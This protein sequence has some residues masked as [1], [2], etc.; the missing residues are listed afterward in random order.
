MRP[1]NHISKAAIAIVLLINVASAQNPNPRYGKWKLKSNAPAPMSNIMTYEP[2]GGHGMKI[3][4]DAV[5][6][7]GVKSQWFYTTN[8]DGKDEPI[9]G[10]PGADTGSV[11]VINSAI[12][13]IVYKKDGKI[14]QVLTN[15]LSPDRDTIGIIYMRM[16][17]SGKTA[18]VT[19]ATYER[20]K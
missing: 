20:M 16:D 3:T 12:N 5:N 18:G 15:V 19:F 4:I 7:D 11:K 14:A 2:S 10:N 1:P 8:F 17:D 13:E 6:K 9:S